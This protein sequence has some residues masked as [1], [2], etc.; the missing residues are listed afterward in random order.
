MPSRRS[1]L[2]SALTGLVVVPFVVPS[3][4]FA[5]APFAA[6][7]APG[8]YRLKIG[9]VEVTALSDGTVALPLA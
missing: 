4:T 8:F 3:V 9:T 2:K 6:V 5:K 1:I 7:Q